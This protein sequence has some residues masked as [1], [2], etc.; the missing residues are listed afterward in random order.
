V[1]NCAA[2]C[3][4]FA[5][6]LCIHPITLPGALEDPCKCISAFREHSLFFKGYINRLYPGQL[7]QCESL[8]R[9]VCWPECKVKVSGDIQKG[10]K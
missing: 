2:R 1:R 7:V 3:T 9:Y 5:N 6:V 4:V 8:L 10:F